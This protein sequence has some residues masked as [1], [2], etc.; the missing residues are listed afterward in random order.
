MFYCT[1]RYLEIVF[2]CRYT[3]YKSIAHCVCWTG[4]DYSMWYFQLA[5]QTRAIL[6]TF[7]NECCWDQHCRRKKTSISHLQQPMFFL[8][9]FTAQRAAWRGRENAA[10]RITFSWS[11]LLYF[12]ALSH[13]PKHA[14]IVT[15]S[16]TYSIL[17]TCTCRGVP[18]AMCACYSFKLLFRGW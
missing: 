9:P 15:H 3:Y 1:E 14:S 5:K 13:C 17:Y 11:T 8:L 10:D 18:T 2:V 16:H 6:Y 4:C 7:R 12:Q